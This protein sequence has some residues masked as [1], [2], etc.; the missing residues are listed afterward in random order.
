MALV[1][2][3]LPTE[4]LRK[5]GHTRKQTI[6]QYLATNPTSK[7]IWPTALYSGTCKSPDRTPTKRTKQRQ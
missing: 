3:G 6:T 7:V 1:P 5:E 2:D 4:K